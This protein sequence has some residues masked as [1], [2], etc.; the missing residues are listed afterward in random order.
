MTQT[1][2]PWADFRAELRRFVLARTHDAVTAD[3]VVQDVLLRAWQS[4]ATLRDDENFRGWLYRITRNALV[5][6]ARRARRR[7]DDVVLTDDSVPSSHG[8]DRAAIADTPSGPDATLGDEA[9]LTACVRSLV[10]QLAEAD[11]IAITLADLEGRK[12]Q[13][14]ADTLGLSISGAKSRVQRARRKLRD[15][16]M[17]CCH[18][19]FDA[20]GRVVDCHDPDACTDC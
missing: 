16:F 4:R 3:D 13:E 1:S 9:D 20:G 12:Q 2:V 11:R 17:A 14:V 5:D 10:A 15:S 18:L 6:R 8:A 19:E 7:P